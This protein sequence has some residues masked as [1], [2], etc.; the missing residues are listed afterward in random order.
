[1]ENENYDRDFGIRDDNVDSR[2][3]DAE[4]DWE[5]KVTM[6][7]KGGGKGEAKRPDNETSCIEAV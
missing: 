1:M 4:V 7:T 5:S 2:K 3:Q 6:M